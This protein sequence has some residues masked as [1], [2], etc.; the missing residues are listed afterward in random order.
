MNLL[1]IKQFAAP[2]N[3]QELDWGRAASSLTQLES[4]LVAPVDPVPEV[5]KERILE[6]V[7]AI[8]TQPKM[9]GPGRPLHKQF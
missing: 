9:A 3:V 5:D 7:R 6:C 2:I 1:E 4:K 8:G